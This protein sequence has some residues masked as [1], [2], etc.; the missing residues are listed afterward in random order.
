MWKTTVVLVAVFVCTLSQNAIRG[1]VPL[2]WNCAFHVRITEQGSSDYIESYRIM[3]DGYTAYMLNYFYTS[4]AFYYSYAEFDLSKMSYHHYPAFV[5]TNKSGQ[6]ET[7]DTYFGGN[8]GSSFEFTS[9][10]EVVS[11]PD[12]RNLCTQYCD[13]TMCIVV[14]SYNRLVE[15]IYPKHDEVSY[16]KYLDD[17]PTADMFSVECE[18]STYTAK[19][20]CPRKVVNLTMDCA[21]HVQI[22]YSDSSEITDS[23]QMMKDGYT[24]YMLNY[25]HS[26]TGVYYSYAAFDLS[27]V[28]YRYDPALTVRNSSGQCEIREGLFGGTHC[29]FFYH[30]ADPEVIQCPKSTDNCDKYCDS[31][32]CIVV[33]SNRRLVQEVYLNSGITSYYSYIAGAPSADMFTV[34]CNGNTYTADDYCAEDPSSSSSSLSSSSSGSS[35]TSVSSDAH[36]SSSSSVSSVASGSPSTPG[37]SSSTSSHS[38]MSASSINEVAITIV[39]TSVMLAIF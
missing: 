7:K 20:Y 38:M 13:D 11:C 26:S 5:A 3:K 18:G 27:K 39:V 21:Y 9:G 25:V 14:D 37:L 10:P 4:N 33:D 12:S 19:D 1:S 31:T 15:E 16:F 32:L 30:T 17:I 2:N 36:G 8:H 23:Y 34:E 22:T 35:S 29:S 28:S 24:A 6:C